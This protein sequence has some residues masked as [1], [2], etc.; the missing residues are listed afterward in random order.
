M[1]LYDFAF[2]CV[3][4]G[5]WRV[6]DCITLRLSH[7]PVQPRNCSNVTRPFPMPTQGLRAGNETNDVIDRDVTDRDVTR[8][9][10]VHL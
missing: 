10:V 5:N 9:L 8:K 1:Q 4:T 6:I 3:A 2:H 7:V